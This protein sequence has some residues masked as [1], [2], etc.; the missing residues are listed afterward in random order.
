MITFS[1]YTHF[2]NQE[3][4]NEAE[5]YLKFGPHWSRY[6]MYPFVKQKI[7]FKDKDVLDIGGG[8]CLFADYLDEPF[9]TFDILDKNVDSCRA[10]KHNNFIC[11]DI[12]KKSTDKKYDI[13]LCLSVLEHIKDWRESLQNMDNCL[14]EGGELVLVLDIF[15]SQRQFSISQIPEIL[16]ILSNYNLGEVDL[17]MND[18]WSLSYVR[19]KLFKKF[20]IR[21]NE[22]DA[23][24][25]NNDVTELFISGK[26]R[27]QMESTKIYFPVE[28]DLIV[29]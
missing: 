19:E 16:T 20:L 24:S 5:R 6:W 17:S 12:S 1:K 28:K 2:E 8:A 11:Q 27:K 26:K 18:L 15:G 4:E 25:S 13:V 22:H 14:K 3:L 7:N 9:K 10:T 23:V 21:K 29:Y